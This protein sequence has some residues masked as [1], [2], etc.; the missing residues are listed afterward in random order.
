[1]LR[2]T[3]KPSEDAYESWVEECHGHVYR[4]EDAYDAKKKGKAASRKPAD[5]LITI[6]G[7]SCL[8]EVKSTTKKSLSFSAIRPEQWRN[9]V[10]VTKAAGIYTFVMHFI[11]ENKWFAVPAQLLINSTKQSINILEVAEYEFDI[12][13]FEPKQ[14]SYLK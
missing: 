4:F 5:Y 14:L 8:T 12:T 2:N 6:G 10:K 13:K 1:M 3:G 9:A 7:V 11:D